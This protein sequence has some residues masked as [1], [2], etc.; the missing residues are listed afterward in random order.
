MKTTANVYRLARGATELRIDDACASVLGLAEGSVLYVVAL[1]HAS[2]EKA[3]TQS[4]PATG[5]SVADAAGP[6]VKAEDAAVRAQG[7]PGPAGD[8]AASS[9]DIAAWADEK[10]TVFVGC[11]YPTASWSNLLRASFILE[12]QSGMLRK[13]VHALN[14]LRIFLRGIEMTSSVPLHEYSL[15]S[16]ALPR[17]HSIPAA[18]GEQAAVP[19]TV[20]LVLEVPEP[21]M[22]DE[23]ARR[24][25]R[26]NSA[27]E[28]LKTLHEAIRGL[29]DWQQDTRS[30]S[31][32]G[33]GETSQDRQRD[34]PPHPA[35][36]AR[37]ALQRALVV[38]G[39]TCTVEWISGLRTTR[40]IARRWKDPRLARIKTILGSPNPPVDSDEQTDSPHQQVI[41]DYRTRVTRDIERDLA[42]HGVE[43]LRGFVE[44]DARGLFVSAEQWRADMW[45][46]Q[47]RFFDSGHTA[48][49]RTE[50]KVVI[51]HADS[52]ERIVYWSVRSLAR[53]C[54]AAFTVTFPAG[55]MESV[56]YEWITDTI[57]REEH[58]RGI[59]LSA[60]MTARSEP[61]S[62]RLQIR[63]GRWASL[64]L[65]VQFDDICDRRSAQK[66]LACF[67]ALQGKS[68]DWEDTLIE[69]LDGRSYIKELLPA[70]EPRSREDNRWRLAT[71]LSNVTL[72]HE[73]QHDAL[74]Q[75]Q[76]W[77]WPNPFDFTRPWTV[78]RCDG[79]FRKMFAGGA[80]KPTAAAARMDKW[81]FQQLEAEQGGPSRGTLVRRILRDL[82]EQYMRYVA[83]VGAHRSGKTS[84]LRRVESVL[85]DR[86][87]DELSNQTRSEGELLIPVLIN[88]AVCP[89]VHLAVTILNGIL[90]SFSGTERGKV[91]GHVDLASV[92]DDVMRE[93]VELAASLKQR[94][95]LLGEIFAPEAG[96]AG[97][98]TM[99]PLVRRDEFL[100]QS[101]EAL[102]AVLKLTWN[103]R[104]ARLVVLLDD[105]AGSGPWMEP[106][107]QAFWREL[108]EA[109]GLREI[110]WVVSTSLS[111]RDVTPHSPIS[112]IF[113]E[114]NLDPLDEYETDFLINE[115]DTGPGPQ[116]DDPEQDSRPVLTLSARRFLAW[117]SARLPYLLQICCFCLFE[118]AKRMRIPVLTTHVAV[119]VLDADVLPQLTDYLEGEWSRLPEEARRHVL[120]ALAPWPDDARQMLFAKAD[121]GSQFANSPPPVQKALLR[122][123]LTGAREF[124]LVAPLVAFW[125]RRSGRHV[126]G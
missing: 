45:T 61:R 1:E 21:A 5:A 19:A 78:E 39:C 49:L 60:Q 87:T 92:S 116:T 117:V 23:E 9:A 59:I 14:E 106:W 4:P 20:M 115:I 67:V 66:I 84:I 110:S 124:G 7:V 22:L 82:Q 121:T 89:P 29:L 104:S 30:H 65:L 2:G 70:P 31:V 37:D 3:K 120:R 44:R 43:N 16:Q 91:D 88:A 57:A 13:L 34:K 40:E 93:A 58:G 47:R 11:P 18:V 38:L 122:S 114:Y 41:D 35:P 98:A 95:S 80:S 17:K 111:S 36:T 33:A 85:R 27:Y 10:D 83:I 86:L 6:G 24:G 94:E 113:Y 119:D 32:P 81:A 96:R 54:I 112:S 126:G 108:V 69:L 90:G 55:G 68:N 8:G 79:E 26:A 28:G 74:Y 62:D 42:K 48:R 125:L 15:L 75:I 52:D 46:S 101:R 99:D 25:A 63:G 73:E 77:P 56:W 103:G 118:R 50:D 105:L 71:I 102:E 53:R 51:T 76:F 97:K 123:G 72:W 12:H 107:A 64:R 100:R 109:T